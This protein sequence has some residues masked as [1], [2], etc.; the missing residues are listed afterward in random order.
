V[1]LRARVR[2]RY[3]SDACRR[4]AVAVTTIPLWRVVAVFMVT[5]I[6]LGLS[7]G[8]AELVLRLLAPLP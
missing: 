8:V 6:A 4:S 3:A 5:G 7:L 1:I 2:S